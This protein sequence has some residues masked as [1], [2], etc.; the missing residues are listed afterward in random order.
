MDTQQNR[1]A[2][3]VAGILA[4][5]LVV[6]LILWMNAKKDLDQVLMEGQEEIID[7]RDQITQNCADGINSDNCQDTLDKLEDILIEFK[8]DVQRATTT[9]TGTPSTS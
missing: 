8:R 2:W 1:T 7:V 4:I 9:G 3:V 5:L 6:V